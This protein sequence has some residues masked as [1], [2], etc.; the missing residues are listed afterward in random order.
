MSHP[1]NFQTPHKYAP[2]PKTTLLLMPTEAF[3]KVLSIV[4]K[5]MFH[6]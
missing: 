4:A 3:C 2:Y 1:N 5:V 6:I